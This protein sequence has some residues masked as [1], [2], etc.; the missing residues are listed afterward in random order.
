MSDKSITPPFTSNKILSPSV[1]YIG[2]KA[3]ESKME[4]ADC[5]G[6]CLKQDKISFSHRKIVNIYIVYEIE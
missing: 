5:N 2:T 6:D 3:R 1:D 4:I